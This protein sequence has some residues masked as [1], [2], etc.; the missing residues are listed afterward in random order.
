MKS[1][2][3][4]T[5]LVLLYFI[6]VCANAQTKQYQI[7]AGSLSAEVSPSGLISLTETNNERFAWPARIFTSL[8]SCEI[9]SEEEPVSLAG[10]GT[11]IRRL[12]KRSGTGFSC[13][14]TQ[15]FRPADSGLRCEIEIKG[16]GKP[17]TAPIKTE[18]QYRPNEA[19]RIWAPWGDLRIS[20]GSLSET[21]IPEAEN[22]RPDQNWTDPLLPR[23]FF[24]DTLFYGAPY[25]SYEKPGIAFIPFQWNLFCIPM[26]S[27]LETQNDKGLSVILDPSD[28]ILDLTMEIKSNGAVTFSRL[29]N[30][31]SDHN[32]LKFSFDIV[33]HEADWR[34][35]LRWMS[36]TYPE[37]FNPANPAADAMAGTGAYSD[38]DTEFDVAKMRRMAFSVNWRASF[39]FPYMGMFIPP[40][41]EDVTWTR[42]GGRPTSVQ[43]M[44]NYSE[45]MLKLGFHVLSYFNVTEFGAKM[46]YPLEPV[47]VGDQSELWKSANDFLA[48]K[49]PGA[50]LHVPDRV[51]QEKLGFYAKTRQGGAYFTWEDGVVM[52]C[53]EPSYREFLMDQARRHISLIPSSEGICIDR[54]D[55]LRMYNENRDDSISWYIDRPARS[56]ITS[57]KDLM[58]ELAPLMHANRKVIFVNNHDKRIDLL[59]NTDGIFDEFTYAGVPLNLTSLMCINRPA[60][61]WTADNGPI[62]SEGCDNFFQK[63]LYLGVFPMAPFPGNDHSIKPDDTTDRQYEDYGPLL[64]MMRGKKWVLDPHCTEVEGG[65]AKVNLFS[66]P[67]GL[68]LPVVFGQKESVVVDVRNLRDTDIGSCMAFY[69]GTEKGIKLKTSSE[70]GYLR[71]EVPLKRG[72][73]IVKIENVKQNKLNK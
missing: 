19:T 49:L 45:K 39:D 40:V 61:G 28:D 57:W 43:A 16:T 64:A 71:I 73:A 42:F 48:A 26:V 29:F 27:I 4:S 68:V 66:V 41:K 47:K 69:P 38:S 1:Y 31:I 20:R 2:P 23:R 18:I 25:F 44:Q 50:M 21:G 59:K 55:W 35:G 22:I 32:V 56:L 12:L 52:D 5:L 51:P 11:E 33:V 24:N 67:G 15:R 14:L 34:G 3:R 10:G 6:F 72:C 70:S 8:D 13:Y 60:L 46:K 62:K 30:R 9:V 7:A 53:G 65:T 17:W 54:L 58:K 37:Y 63:Y 36:M